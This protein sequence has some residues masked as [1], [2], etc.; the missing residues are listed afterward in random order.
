MSKTLILYRGDSEK[1]NEFKYTKTDKYCLLGKGIY[2]TDDPK[3][4]DTYRTKGMKAR[5][6]T[7]FYNRISQTMFSGK[8]KN[9]NDAYEKAFPNFCRDQSRFHELGSYKDNMTQKQYEKFCQEQRVIY[10]EMISQGDILSQYLSPSYRN[11]DPELIVKYKDD[12]NKTNKIGYITE[13]HFDKDYLMNN[14]LHADARYVDKNFWRIMYE[15]GIKIGEGFD[16]SID[17]YIQTNY[18]K[19]SILSAVTSVLGGF[20]T[21]EKVKYF[22]QI[23]QVMSQYGIIGYRYN[24]GLISNGRRHS[25]FCIWDDDFVNKHKVDVYR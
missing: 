8:A 9:R 25:A 19:H 11:A 6:H 7:K 17:L 13:F 10:N 23:E 3:L 15:N 20:A 24:G 5:D 4:A 22:K 1:I 18:H 2:L 21:V 14:V 16:L 12:P